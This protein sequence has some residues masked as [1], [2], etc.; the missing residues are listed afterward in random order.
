M[1]RRARVCGLSK[2]PGCPSLSQVVTGMTRFLWAKEAM[3]TSCC[4]PHSRIPRERDRNC[5]TKRA[6]CSH[7]CLGLP[8]QLRNTSPASFRLPLLCG[9]LPCPMVWPGLLSKAFWRYCPQTGSPRPLA[10]WLSAH[11]AHH[12]GLGP[13]CCPAS[14]LSALPRGLW[15]SPHT[16]H[17]E[18]EAWL[19]SQSGNWF[20]F[21]CR[22]SVA[23]KGQTKYEAQP[24]VVWLPSASPASAHSSAVLLSTCSVPGTLPT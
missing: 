1:S 6:R 9:G 15:P 19:C 17:T 12:R 7:P 4:C 24:L 8:L 18:L 23:C 21:P 13:F 22:S 16:R 3:T 11:R 10:L 5:W 20:H 14:E 2:V